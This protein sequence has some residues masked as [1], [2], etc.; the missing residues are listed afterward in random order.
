[1]ANADPKPCCEITN[2]KQLSEMVMKLD[3]YLMSNEPQGENYDLGIDFA[4]A[5]HNWL[6]SSLQTLV[7]R[8]MVSMKAD[9]DKGGVYY[10]AEQSQSMT[11]RLMV[12]VTTQTIIDNEDTL[13]IG[14]WF[15]LA[16]Y[17]NKQSF[18]D[19]ATHYFKNEHFFEKNPSLRFAK[20][21]AN[22]Q[23]L[24]NMVSDNYVNDDIW[25]CFVF[26]T[27][28][29]DL[30]YA[31][32]QSIGINRDNIYS[33]NRSAKSCFVGYYP[34]DINVPMNLKAIDNLDYVSSN[35]FYFSTS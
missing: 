31:Y 12:F 8:G 34:N 10:M 1:M 27:F 28:D 9:C 26:S 33:L 18:I 30:M 29:L 19:D 22:S 15:D 24:S 35:G 7:K 11:P 6:Q 2:A 14:K 25:A 5:W 21:E 23:F 4:L 17:P 13:D 3:P 20:V 32:I 16:S